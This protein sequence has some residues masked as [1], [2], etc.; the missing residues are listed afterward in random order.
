MSR[1]KIEPPTETANALL[2]FV[3]MKTVS[4]IAIYLL[5]R[6]AFKQVEKARTQ[7]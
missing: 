1:K 6:R 7:G 4:G 3:L 5:M 2:A